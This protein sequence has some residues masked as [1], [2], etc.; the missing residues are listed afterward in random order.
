MFRQRLLSVTF[1]EEDS[2]FSASRR[3]ARRVRSYPVHG[4]VKSK[5]LDFE[6]V[7]RI[8]IPFQA[9]LR[10]MDVQVIHDVL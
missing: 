4:T 6:F 2:P 5:S 3:V 1:T 10:Q 8:P 7:R 9:T